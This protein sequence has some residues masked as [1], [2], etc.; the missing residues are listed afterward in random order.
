MADE[1]ADDEANPEADW[2]QH[3][4][5]AFERL[6][7]DWKEA[8]PDCA[9]DQNRLWDL[10]RLLHRFSEQEIQAAMF[11]SVEIYVYRRKQTYAEAWERIG[12]ICYN[13][14]NDQENPNKRLFVTGVTCCEAVLGHVAAMRIATPANSLSSI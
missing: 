4:A 11:P 3:N 9:L 12:G 6:I 8:A 13:S 2:R 14:R 7:N 10:K 5:L 1:D